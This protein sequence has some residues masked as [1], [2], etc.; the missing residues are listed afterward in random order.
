MSSEKLP[1]RHVLGYS[2]TALSASIF[3]DPLPTILVAFY[4]MN[5]SLSMAAIGTVMLFSRLFDAITDPLIGILS[6][7]TNTPI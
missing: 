3:F 5:T 2:T 6:D 7:K 1:T 4:A